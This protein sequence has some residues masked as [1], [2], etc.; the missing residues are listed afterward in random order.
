[1]YKRFILENAC[2]GKR[3]K[4]C[5]TGQGEPLDVNTGLTLMKEESKRRAGLEVSDHSTVLRKHL[6]G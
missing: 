2:E 4:E 1:M 3:G 6:P 5:R